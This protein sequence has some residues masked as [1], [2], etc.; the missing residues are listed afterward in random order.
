[1]SLTSTRLVKGTADVY[2]SHVV[3]GAIPN[4]TP[5]TGEPAK[6]FLCQFTGIIAIAGQ[7]QRKGEQARIMG[8]NRR[9]H[10]RAHGD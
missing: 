8:L 3:F 6:G 7:A 10:V 1:M 4:L 5:L 9:F 2:D